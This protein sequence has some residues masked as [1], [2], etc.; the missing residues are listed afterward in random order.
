MEG[1]LPLYDR[2]VALVS[3]RGPRSMESGVMSAVSF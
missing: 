3:F 2:P 1:W